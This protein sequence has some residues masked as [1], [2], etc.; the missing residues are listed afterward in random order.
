MKPA[1]ITELPTLSLPSKIEAVFQKLAS[2]TK[3]M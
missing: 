3:L 1:E 2:L